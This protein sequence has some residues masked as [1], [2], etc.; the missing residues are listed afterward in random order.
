MVSRY[1]LNLVLQ[2]KKSKIHV[3]PD[4]GIS[5]HSLSPGELPPVSSA[6]VD[7]QSFEVIGGAAKY[8]LVKAHGMTL[9]SLLVT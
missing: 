7:F 5:P 6:Q 2:S 1:F 9:K 4:F 8:L 3:F